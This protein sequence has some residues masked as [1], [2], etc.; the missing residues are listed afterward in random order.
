[1]DRR[2]SANEIQ[3]CIEIRNNARKNCN[4]LQADEYRETLRQTGVAVMD[5]KGGR[6]R[7][8]DV[9]TWKYWKPFN[10]SIK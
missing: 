7:G 3:T 6:G 4:F 1:M 10:S 8:S 9:T 2:P 5:E